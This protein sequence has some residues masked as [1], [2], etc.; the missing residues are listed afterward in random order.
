MSKKLLDVSKIEAALKRAGRV[1]INGSPDERAGRL[2]VREADSGR[3]VPKKE[4]SKPAK[5]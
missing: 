2:M 3:F 5:K 4:T 1:A